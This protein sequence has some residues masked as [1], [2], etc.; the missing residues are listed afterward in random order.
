MAEEI[1]STENISEAKQVRMQKLAALVEAGQDPFVE[2]KFDK[3]HSSK[4]IK[5][6]AEIILLSS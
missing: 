1:V 2:V 6:N 5:D 4:D 3:T